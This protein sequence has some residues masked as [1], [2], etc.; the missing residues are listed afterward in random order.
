MHR[1]PFATGGNFV[2]SLARYTKLV[3]S[4]GTWTFDFLTKDV[5]NLSKDGKSDRD[6]LSR[7]GVSGGDGK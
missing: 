1:N 4:V 3:I 2:F 5:M 7:G 6:R